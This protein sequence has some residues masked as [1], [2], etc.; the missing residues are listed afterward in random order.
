MK[1]QQMMHS[2]GAG[3]EGMMMMGH[4]GRMGHEGM[5][6]SGHGSGEYSKYG[7]GGGER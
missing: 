3:G 1:M 5:M 6:K 4:E 2:S 7:G